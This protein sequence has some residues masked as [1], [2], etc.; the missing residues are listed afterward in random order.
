MTAPEN[1]RYIS[2]RGENF[3]PVIAGQVDA[4][5]FGV[6]HVYWGIETEARSYEVARGL[7]RAGKH[8]GVAV[9][10][11]PR[12]CNGCRAGGPD[13]RF[14]ILYTSYSLEDAKRYMAEKTQA[15]GW[16]PRA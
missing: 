5:G 14:H 8:L 12:E 7:R 3:D 9:K 4:V 11:Y 10:A 1:V 16:R 13:C 15:L 2:R 6:E